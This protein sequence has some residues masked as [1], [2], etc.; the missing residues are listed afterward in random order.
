MERHSLALFS[1]KDNELDFVKVAGKSFGINEGVDAL[2]R[3]C[4]SGEY[5]KS[6]CQER[7]DE[8]RINSKLDSDYE[9]STSNKVNQLN[10]DFQ[11]ILEVRQ[12]R[13]M[14]QISEHKQQPAPEIV[15]DFADE[16]DFLK[17]VVD[18]KLP[19]VESYLARRADPNTCDSFKCTVLHR[20]CSQGNVE[21]VRRLLETG[22]LIENKD[23]LDATAVHWACRGG[24]LPVLELLLNHK[25]NIHAKDKLQSTPLHVAVRTGHYECAEHLIHCG[26]DINAKDREGDTPMHDAVRLNRFKFI[27]LLLLH[28][29]NPKLK[30]YI[31][32]RMHTVPSTDI[33][34]G[35][36]PMDSVLQWQ[37]GAKTILDNYKH[38]KIEQ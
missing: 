27:Q 29:A 23:K 14:S 33:W 15:S 21:I 13:K 36:S 1:G 26:A 38:N 25:G 7:K 16:D 35:K 19:M 2:K 30:N 28:G 20:A 18:N 11:K 10:H 24:S 8:L 6:I 31:W 34:E 9:I 17:A 4:L 12:R 3:E 37:N 32:F 22:A 5:E